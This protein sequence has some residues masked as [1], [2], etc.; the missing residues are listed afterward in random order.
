MSPT[1]KTSPN[2]QDKGTPLYLQAYEKL[3]KLMRKGNIGDTLPH[4]RELAL[5]W[6][7]SRITIR[8]AY[9]KL[10]EDG[11]ALREHKAPRLSS[12]G[13]F[14][15]EGFTHDALRRG[16]QPHTEIVGTEII[17]PPIHISKLL[18][19]SQK[20]RVYRLIRKRY[21]EERLIALEY[22]HISEKLAPGLDSHKLDS[23]YDVLEKKYRIRIHRVQ[24]DFSFHFEKTPQ[25]KDLNVPEDKPIMHLQ[26]VS[27]SYKNRPVEFVEAYYDI[28][29]FA[30]NLEIRC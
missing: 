27:F 24:Q 3:V 29:D 22:A 6:G 13:M 5:E 1:K 16:I 9:A 21:W 10:V 28:R 18:M 25:H 2:F 12:S 26:R 20:D 14:M 4:E 19:L 23:L 30:F 15:P 8:N 11:H 17:Y 7:V